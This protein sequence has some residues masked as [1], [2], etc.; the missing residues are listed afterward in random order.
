[1]GRK[2]YGG[3]YKSNKDEISKPEEPIVEETKETEP[4]PVVEETKEEPKT[5]MAKVAGASLVNL[6]ENPSTEGKVLDKLKEGTVVEVGEVLGAWSHVKHAG[7]TGFMM[8]QY[9]KEI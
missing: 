7:K 6:R 9:L 1:M 2:N 3:Y 5:K 8:S 4:A